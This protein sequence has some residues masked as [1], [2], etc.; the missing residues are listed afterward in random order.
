MHLQE[1]AGALAL[2]AQ[3]EVMTGR[4][5]EVAQPREHLRGT[6]VLELA[7]VFV[8]GA[9]AAVVQR[10]FDAPVRAERGRE[11]VGVELRDRAAGEDEDGLGFN[12]AVGELPAAVHARD[13]RDLRK[14]AF[15]AG[16]CAGLDHAG[17]DPAVA[18]GDIV[19]FRGWTGSGWSRA[20]ASPRVGWLAFTTRR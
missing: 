6:A 12:L 1:S 11:G 14:G 2:A 15:A 18:L 7:A 17:F 8:L 3:R 19:P 16:D 20:R 13:L 4:D 10:V 9:V 5:R